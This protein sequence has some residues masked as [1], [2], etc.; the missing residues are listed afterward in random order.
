MVRVKQVYLNP[1]QLA[2]GSATQ[3]FRVWNGGRGSGK[4]V[5]IG[6]SQ[7]QK[8][9]DMPRAKF[10]FSSSTYGQLLTKTLPP[11]TKIWANFGLIE[12]IPGQQNGHYV[13]GKVPPRHWKKP[14]DAPKKFT[15][16]ITF[17]NG[18]TIELLSMD[19]PELNLGGS[20]D[21]G[22][23]D[24][25][26]QVKHNVISQILIPSIRGNTDKFKHWSHGQLSLYTSMPWKADGMY[27]LDYEDKARLDPKN[28][29]YMES[30]SWDNWRIIGK[31]S[32]RRM[33]AE[34]KPSIYDIEIMNKRHGKSEICF[35]H[36]FDDKRHLYENAYDYDE[37]DLFGIA[38]KSIK[39]VDTD[40]M[41]DIS[42]DFGGWFTGFTVW[43][44]DIRKNTE[45]CKDAFYVPEDK[46]IT[47]LVDNF[48]EKYKDH[49]Y[50]FIKIWGEPRGHDK[51]AT[52]FTYYEQM[53]QRF[54]HHGWHIEIC[55]NTAVSENH[56]N[57]YEFVNVCLDETNP[58]LPKIRMNA[59]TCKDVVISIHNTEVD[60]NFK[61]IK[62]NEK[63][64]SYNQAHATHYTDTFDY[65]LM[66]KH[67]WKFHM[68]GMS[69]SAGMVIFR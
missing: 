10:F 60:N 27:I 35:Y 26:A 19:R 30:T 17:R 65:Y 33:K 61:K 67:G 9:G 50:K 37:D 15:H 36:A 8:M 64:R 24:E 44:E 34:M 32:L 25:A 1:K 40:L 31:K 47:Q 56:E 7:R 12:H 54:R 18:Y 28:Y 6:V 46:G 4:S 53:E 58:D 63:N 43:Q 59:D 55:V 39:N 22:E 3:P 20:F 68:Y 48:C 51:N 62:K 41:I 42:C 13:I 57:R 2:F 52:G 23:I 5:M 38:I 45:Y 11:I 66:Q 69:G 21:G 29:F 49:R 16:V 14:Y